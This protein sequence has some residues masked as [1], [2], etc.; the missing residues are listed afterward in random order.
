MVW[1]SI[2]TYNGGGKVGFVFCGIYLLWWTRVSGDPSIMW[3]FDVS[4]PQ[5]IRWRIRAD[6]CS[7]RFIGVWYYSVSLRSITKRDWVS[8]VTYWSRIALF[9]DDFWVRD[10]LRLSRLHVCSQS[11]WTNILYDG[12]TRHRSKQNFTV[13]VL[14]TKTKS[15]YP[16]KIPP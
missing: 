7:N 10:A 9:H 5:G 12:K 11:K 15:C 16:S 6:W 4:S 13:P 2:T 8:S 3:D 1:V 14:W